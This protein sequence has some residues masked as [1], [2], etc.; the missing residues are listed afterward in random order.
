MAN[1]RRLAGRL[2]ADAGIDAPSRPD[3]LGPI[4]EIGSYTLAGADYPEDVRLLRRGIAALGLTAGVEIVND[5]FG[6]MRAGSSRPWG[7][8]LICG[9]GINAAG[10]APDGRSWRFDSVGEY[11]GDWGGGGGI[12]R[13]ALAA[14]VRGR[15]GR[16]PR[17]SLERLVPAYFG[18]STP[19]ALTR[20]LYLGKADERRITRMAPIVFGA[21][22]AGDAVARSII[23]RLADELAAMASIV[24][25]KLRL[26]RLD[27]D[28]V[29]AGGVFRNTDAAFHDRLERGVLAAAPRARLVPCASPP[30]A[31]S[32]LL[33][34]DRLSAS[35][36]TDPAAEQRL[37]AE[38]T[39]EMLSH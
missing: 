18:V 7:V 23:D 21:A 16:G 8:V 32:A 4:A 12:S 34:L 10:I 1:L 13:E 11:A 9:H 6:A 28:V 30:V 2:A 38:L 33:G 24:I 27:P 26:A 39:Q 37:R 3:G 29:L 19:K 31:G 22:G 15:D 17:T 14:A 25:R 5:T 36:V 35:R 20:A